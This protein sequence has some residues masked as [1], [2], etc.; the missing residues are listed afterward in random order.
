MIKY[1]FTDKKTEAQKMEHNR[2]VALSGL[3][4]RQLESKPML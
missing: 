4:T 1:H 3:E 2:S